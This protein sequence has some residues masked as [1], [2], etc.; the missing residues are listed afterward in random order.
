M[1][2]G[3]KHGGVAEACSIDARRRRRYRPNEPAERLLC[4]VTDNDDEASVGPSIYVLLSSLAVFGIRVLLA[5]LA[6]A[7]IVLDVNHS[8]AIALRDSVFI[9]LRF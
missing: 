2:V 3:N 6:S 8:R 1:K 5:L 4:A 7:P 9:P